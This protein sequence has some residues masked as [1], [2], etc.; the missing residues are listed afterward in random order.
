MADRIYEVE[1]E[2]EFNRAL[3]G[4]MPVMAI[5]YATWCPHCR[6][7]NPMLDR[8]AAPYRSNILFIRIDIDEQPE[9]ADREGIQGV[10]TVIFYQDGQNVHQWVGEQEPTEYQQVLD[11]ALARK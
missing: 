1:S 3:K 4:Q 7:L 9:L 10:P 5:F 8:L 6:V 11:E 2:A